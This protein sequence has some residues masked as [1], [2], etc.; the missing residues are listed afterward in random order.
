MTKQKVRTTVLTE[1][2]VLMDGLMVV[3]FLAAYDPLVKLQIP[4]LTIS[5]CLAILCFVT[6]VGIK[7]KIA[8]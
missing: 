8:E 4:D 7:L 3:Y 1:F 2:T 6:S 5:L